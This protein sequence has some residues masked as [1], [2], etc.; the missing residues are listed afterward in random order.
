MRISR[1]FLAL[2]IVAAMGLQALA[3]GGDTTAPLKVIAQTGHNEFFQV[4]FSSDDQLL[5]S[6]TKNGEIH[7]WEVS[8]LKQVRSYIGHA[9]KL[10]HFFV[11]DQAMVTVSDRNVF[12]WRSE[13]EQPFVTA[14]LFDSVGDYTTSI[15]SVQP[16]NSHYLLV[17]Q[18]VE[19]ADTGS[20]SYAVG[21]KVDVRTGAQQ[22]IPAETLNVTLV[23]RLQPYLFNIS[24]EV[25]DT[26]YSLLKETSPGHWDTLWQQNR[27]A[28]EVTGLE[29]DPDFSPDGHYLVFIADGNMNSDRTLRSN[30][31]PYRILPLGDDVAPLPAKTVYYWMPQGE[32]NYVYTDGWKRWTWMN[33]RM[34]ESPVSKAEVDS[35]FGFAYATN[36]LRQWYHMGADTRTTNDQYGAIANHKGNLFAVTDTA[37]ISLQSYPG[38]LLRTVEFTVA[39][40]LKIHVAKDGKRYLIETN[41]DYLHPKRYWEWQFGQA[42]PLQ[43]QPVEDSASRLLF[44]SYRLP[45][46]DSGFIGGKYKVVVSKGWHMSYYRGVQ[47]ITLIDSIGKEIHLDG[48][49]NE[50]TRWAFNPDET[51][52]ASVSVKD[53]NASQTNEIK[54][55]KISKAIEWKRMLD[56]G[57]QEDFYESSLSSLSS[58]IKQ[59]AFTAD[60]KFLW[61]SYPK[62]LVRW[63][64]QTG[65]PVQEVEAFAPFALATGDSLMAA[66][67]GLGQE[68]IVFDTRSNTTLWKFSAHNAEITDV[69]FMNNNRYLLTA[70]KDGKTKIWDLTTG[71]EV[72]DVVLF[73]DGSSYVMLT[74]KNYYLGSRQ[75]VSALNF[76]V[77]NRAYSYEQFD[78]ALN[79]PDVVLKEIESGADE[80]LIQALHAAWK[81]RVKSLGISEAAA[82]QLPDLGRLPAA[83]LQTVEELDSITIIHA[84]LSATDGRQ[85]L[86][87]QVKVNGI[88]IY[89]GRGKLFAAPA[90]S[91][92]IADTVHLVPGA[93]DIQL[94]CFDDSARESLRQQLFSNS[95][96]SEQPV[97]RLFIGIGVS[98]YA[99]SR[100][101]L[102]YPA[103]DVNDLS[104]TFATFNS[105][106]TDE[107]VIGKVHPK[108]SSILLR[109]EQATRKNILALKSRLTRTLP[110]DEVI[111]SFNGH[112]LIDRNLNFYFASYDINFDEPANTGLSYADI[113]WLLD[114]IPAR[115]RM[116]LMDAC[117]S[118]PLDKEN[119]Y[120][121]VIDTVKKDGT[122]SYIKV[123]NKTETQ[124]AMQLNNTFKLMQNLFADISE[125]NGAIVIAAAGGDEY[126]LEGSS[127]NNG[128]FTYCLRSA[129]EEEAADLNRDGS[130]SVEELKSFVM[131]KV[132]QLT[133]GR[134]KPTSRQDN[135]RMQWVL[136]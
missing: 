126:A 45:V 61:G 26:I 67:A 96:E 56:V 83:N 30:S 65:V 125:S 19:I 104:N 87:Y 69:Q 23:N 77:N 92:S 52:L 47:R 5:Y 36:D 113:T 4:Q 130:I 102:Q 15:V 80:K 97:Q 78:L 12:I 39:T 44:A 98:T 66:T 46:A 22:R 71:K 90:G 81:K 115:K 18:R 120:E 73:K 121:V 127:W 118:G 105:P 16:Y 133:Q 31:I 91:I 8:T 2:W 119:N 70:S 20:T 28:L 108:V 3:S 17:S 42:F 58:S 64:V 60:S 43:V 103:K 33:N 51:L 106:K 114:G 85:L 99:D 128:V 112:G 129:L 123:K 34:V 63:S 68:V 109:N 6:Y 1:L 49:L 9:G 10:N 76:V 88:P 135:P 24:Y 82:A 11:Y 72:F 89:P 48:H 14:K 54:I 41:G 13:Q 37:A 7:A 117:H 57:K 107:D 93:N 35:A 95:G 21:W 50:V 86:G 75:S 132:E 124:V 131:K 134:Q 25:A 62:K 27:K 29:R 110:A 116:V 94:Y 38:K 74:P 122:R 32:K 53:V 111:I 100:F 40:P 59:L 79:R 84:R 55:W 136:R 101:N